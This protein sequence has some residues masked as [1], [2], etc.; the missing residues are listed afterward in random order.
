MSLK[1]HLQLFQITKLK[2]SRFNKERGGRGKRKEKK[3]IKRPYRHT[4]NLMM[5]SPVP[6]ERYQQEIPTTLEKVTNYYWS[7]PHKR[8]EGK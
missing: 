1:C 4:K 6:L 7:G 5:R 2:D 3:E 8:P